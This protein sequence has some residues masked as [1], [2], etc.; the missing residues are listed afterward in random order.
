MHFV[1][2]SAAN[3]NDLKL[4]KSF[5]YCVPRRQEHLFAKYK[6][7]DEVTVTW[8]EVTSGLCQ[9]RT[10]DR[11]GK[12]D[13]WKTVK[14]FQ[15]VTAKS[16]DPLDDGW[17]FREGQPDVMSIVDVYR[18]VED[19]AKHT[20][21]EL[22]IFCHAWEGGPVMVDSYDDRSYKDAS[23]KRVW[24]RDEAR[25][26]DDKDGRARDFDPVNRNLA[27]FRD[28]F[29]PA[30]EFRIWGCNHTDRDV[31]LFK[32]LFM[33]KDYRRSG[34]K[35]GLALQL[36]LPANYDLEYTT[37]GLPV[38]KG[39][40]S[41]TFGDLRR[42]FEGEL[43]SGYNAKAAKGAG[44]KLLGGAPGNGSTFG[45]TA[46]FPMVIVATPGHNSRIV[47]F[48]REYLGVSFDAASFAEY[49]P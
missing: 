33:H 36:V 18:F 41:C 28:A 24:I 10:M 17:A 22:S 8:F 45:K 42:Y 34:M 46:E 12:R 21:F 6:G 2:V 1:L 16:Y 13:N 31:D 9:Q 38:A 30:A 14:R 37:R 32:R 19:Q 3:A 29:N 43:K 23:G 15:A 49:P 25:D 20:V 11:A 27:K 39:K 7:K 48:Y 47:E 44:V 5:Y 26:P 40:L 35:D 4:N